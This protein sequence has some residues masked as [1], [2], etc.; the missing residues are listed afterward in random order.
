MFVFVLEITS[1]LGNIRKNYYNQSN[2]I[3]L[4]YAPNLLLAAW[5]FVSDPTEK[6]TEFSVKANSAFHLSGV[7]K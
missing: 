7:G 5:D 1:I 4:K 6:F 3:W 2:S